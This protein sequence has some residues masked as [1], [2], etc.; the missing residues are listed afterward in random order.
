M[1]FLKRTT[2][3]ILDRLS[4]DAKIVLFVLFGAFVLGAPFISIMVLPL[5]LMGYSFSSALIAVSLTVFAVPLW[6]AL[7]GY[8]GCR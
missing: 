7:L 4:V 3:W 8:L 5:W 2:N 1:P 6:L